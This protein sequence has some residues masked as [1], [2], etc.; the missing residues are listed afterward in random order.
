[1]RKD[2]D[3]TLGI[4]CCEFSH[5]TSCYPINL[6]SGLIEKAACKLL[7][8]YYYYQLYYYVDGTIVLTAIKQCFCDVRFIYSGATRQSQTKKRRRLYNHHTLFTPSPS[9]TH[10]HTHTHKTRQEVTLI[11]SVLSPQKALSLI[12]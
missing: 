2:K 7:F 6:I 12:V 1:M 3:E 4:M 11:V 8:Q 10:R 9:Q 5:A